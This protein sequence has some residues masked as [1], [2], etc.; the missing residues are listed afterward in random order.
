MVSGFQGLGSKLCLLGLPRVAQRSP[1]SLQIVF[2]AA[3]SHFPGGLGH[4]ADSNS[5]P[6]NQP[7]IMRPILSVAILLKFLLLL[8]LRLFLQCHLSRIDEV[9]RFDDSMIDLHNIFQIPIIVVKITFGLFEGSK[10]FDKL[11]SV[12][13]EVCVLHGWD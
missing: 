5:I 11:F 7:T 6:W 13:C 1:A 4:F 12:S 8:V 9:L 3:F 2:R 10:N